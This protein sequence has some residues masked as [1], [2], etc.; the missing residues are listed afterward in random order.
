MVRRDR[1]GDWRSQND[2]GIS[3]RVLGTLLTWVS[4][5]ESLAFIVAT[6]NDISQLPPELVRKGRLD[7]IFFVD[8]PNEAVR[9]DIFELHLRKRNEEPEQFDIDALASLSEGFSGA[10]IEQV[11]VNALYTSAGVDEKLSN[12]Q[13]EG[14]I[15]STNPLSVVMFENVASLRKWAEERCVFAD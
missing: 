15:R 4:E 1:E 14:S 9:K 11:I 3:Q 6:S 8:L 2:S 7:E 10:E 12:V 5:R 13:L